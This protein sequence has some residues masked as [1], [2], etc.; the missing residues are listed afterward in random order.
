[1]PLRVT[2]EVKY[3]RAASGSI[4]T[5]CLIARAEGRLPYRPAWQHPDTKLIGAAREYELTGDQRLRTAATFFW[6]CVARERS[7]INAATPIMSSSRQGKALPIRQRP[8]AETC[9]VYN[10]HKLTRHLFCWDPKAEYADYYELGLFNDLLASQHPETAMTVYFLPLQSGCSKQFGTPFDSMWCC[11]STSM[12]RNCMY[13]NS[14][15][16]HDGKN[17][18]WV[19]LFIAS[20]ITWRTQDVK[21][22]QETRFPTRTRPR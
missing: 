18:L 2:G 6:E 11:T 10:I 19:N 15:Y 13:G 3:L 5:R 22:H 12:E 21:L 1:M 14:I 8:D 9:V 20:E 16:F 17:T 4:I 7:Y